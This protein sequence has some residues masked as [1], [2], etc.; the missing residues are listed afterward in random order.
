MLWAGLSND[1]ALKKALQFYI[2]EFRWYNPVCYYVA[3]TDGV[4]PHPMN[5]IA[6]CIVASL[7]KMERNVKALLLREPL[8]PEVMNLENFLKKD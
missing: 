4:K 5:G 3:M 7:S 2:N 6:I 8:L 1:E